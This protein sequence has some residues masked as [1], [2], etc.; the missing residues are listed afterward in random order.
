MEP[1][2]TPNLANPNYSEHPIKL[3]KAEVTKMTIAKHSP[4]QLTDPFSET[5]SIANAATALGCNPATIRVMI[6]SGEL[7]AYRV[8]VSGRLIR[9]LKSDFQAIFKPFTINTLSEVSHGSET[10]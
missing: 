6:S 4:K 3:Q 7:K 5:M 2:K 1:K 9:I 8:G 10:H